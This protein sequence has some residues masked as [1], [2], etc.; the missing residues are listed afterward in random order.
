MNRIVKSLVIMLTLAGLFGVA[1]NGYS[2]DAKQRLAIIKGLKLKGIVGE[3]NQGLLEFRTG[4]RTASAIVDEENSERTKAYAE[5]AK[6]TGVSVSAVGAQRANQIAQEES[7]GVWIQK[8]DGS[9]Y[10]K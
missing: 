1:I 3:N 4:D 9:W 7:A 2:M 10:K 8:P 6:N 5:I